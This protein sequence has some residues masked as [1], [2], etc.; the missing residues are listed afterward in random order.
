MKKD[1]KKF[2]PENL[3]SLANKVVGIEDTL[4]NLDKHSPANRILKK[5]PSTNPT[6]AEMLT[7]MHQERKNAKRTIKH[8]HHHQWLFVP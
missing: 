2:D 8:H 4:C 1:K 3:E 6:Y 7:K 5:A